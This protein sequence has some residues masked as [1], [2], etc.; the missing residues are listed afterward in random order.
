MT[1][2]EKCELAIERGYVYNPET[3]IV[4]SRFGREITSKKKSYINIQLRFNGKKYELYAHQFAWYWVYKKC[5][6]CLDH[7]NGVR[8]DNHIS[9]LRSV[10]YQENQHNR[11]TAKGYTWNKTANKWKAQ[12]G[13]NGKTIHLGYFNTEEDAKQ[14]YLEAKEK[15]HII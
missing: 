13:L 12:I 14:V 6:D 5:V 11:T 9:N 3:G 2:Q 7:I 8:T 1:R 10:T 15:Y 4:Y